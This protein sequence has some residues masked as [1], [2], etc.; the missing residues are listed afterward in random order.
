MLSRAGAG[1]SRPWVQSQT[2]PKISMMP[3]GR[4]CGLTGVY[5]G[6]KMSSPDL[7][8]MD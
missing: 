7:V 1:R 5:G 3:C 4:M 2:I 6:G 8:S